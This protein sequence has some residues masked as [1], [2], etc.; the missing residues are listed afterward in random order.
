MRIA[1]NVT[2]LIGNT[3][4]VR[5]NRIPKGVNAQIVCKLEY[6]NPLSSVKDRIGVAM[7]EAAEREG[8]LTPDVTVLESTSGNTGI[9]LAFTCAAK[10]YRCMLVMPETMS[11][12]RR[13]LLRALGAELVLTPGPEGMQ[14]AIRK[15]EEIA[16]AAPG[17]YFIPRQFDNPANPEIHRRTTAEEIWRDTDGQCDIL[18]AGVGT[19][20]TIT[21]VGEIIKARKPSFRTVAVEPADSA[22]LSGK[23]KGHHPIQGIG[24]GFIPSILNT[25][26]YDEIITVQNED[27]IKMT[28][29]LAKEEGIFAGISSGAAV[30]A[31]LQVSKREENAGK[32]IVT[33][34]PSTG[35]RYLSTPTYSIYAE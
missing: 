7:I 29:R 12:E 23:P 13:A 16:A 26:V 25:H 20:G 19:G 24:A 6:F 3:P 9:A 22:V 34:I 15:A 2:E 32:M 4:L 11:Q 17:K 33:I 27:A 10:G 21:G 5:L 14:G 30:W 31:A 18:V 1:N 28:R 8:K 35:E